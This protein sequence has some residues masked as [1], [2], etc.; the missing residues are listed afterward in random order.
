MIVFAIKTC[1]FIEV[2]GYSLGRKTQTSYF[3]LIFRE[4]MIR[5]I[6]AMFAVVLEDLELLS[7]N[8]NLL[9]VK[10]KVRFKLHT[11]KC[12][13]CKRLAIMFNPLT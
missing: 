6:S 3:F 10:S 11:Q 13:T 7:N 8:A 2:D 4:E 1:F 12:K 9:L 5:V